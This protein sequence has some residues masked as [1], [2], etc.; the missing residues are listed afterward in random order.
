MKKHIIS[1]LAGLALA[2]TLAFA[3]GLSFTNVLYTEVANFSKAG[4]NDLDVNFAGNNQ[5]YEQ[6]AAGY[7]SE[8]V[9]I[10]AQARINFLT[11]DDKFITGFGYRGDK[12][13][14]SIKYKPV[15]GLDLG[16]GTSYN[17]PGA[18]LAVEDDYVAIGKIGSPGFNV[19]LTGIKNLTV[20]V[21]FDFI[22]GLYNNYFE[23]ESGD[24]Y[25]FN[26]GVGAWYEFKNGKDA[27]VFT[28][29]AAFDYSRAN[30]GNIHAGVYGSA[31]PLEG[32]DLY[33]GFTYNTPGP[34][35]EKSPGNPNDGWKYASTFDP[36]I[37]DDHAVNFS[38]TY[39]KKSFYSA[40]DFNTGLRFKDDNDNERVPAFYAGALLGYNISKDFAVEVS[41]QTFGRYD[42]YMKGENSWVTIQPA[43]IW[44]LSKHN[45]FVFSALVSLAENSFNLSFPVKWTFKL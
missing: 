26:T 40:F 13:F 38:V 1:V 18:Y 36:Y 39:A 16:I 19:A 22:S 17:I 7:T 28:L 3:D 5:T 8:K 32:L 29:G 15:S 12:T 42:E 44:A 41:S 45:T 6:M 21:A 2:G 4:D 30:A 14:F 20:V 10:Y 43:A 23:S 34:V 31:A 11:A 24:K 35:N 33:F 37:R 27:T 25:V 9:D